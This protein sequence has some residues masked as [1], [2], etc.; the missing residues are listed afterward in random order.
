MSSA[1]F[2]RLLNEIA[3]NNITDNILFHIMGEPLLHPNIMDLLRYTVERTKRQHLVTNGSLFN[4]VN[5]KECYE[6]QLTHLSISYFTPNHALF[7]LRNPTNITFLDYQQTIQDVVQSKFEHNYGTH[8]RLFYPNINLRSFTW[9]GKSF[10]LLNK[11]VINTI[12]HTW[13]DFLTELGIQPDTIRQDA[14]RKWNMKKRHS[15]FMTDDFEIVFKPIH[16]WHNSN[17]NVIQAPIGKCSLVLN[18]EQLGILSNGDVVLCCGDYDGQTTFGNITTKSLTDILN[19]DD[20]HNIINRFSKGSIPFD[21][22]KQCLGSQSISSLMWKS[23][24]K[25]YARALLT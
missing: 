16:N 14:I 7:K 11:R 22:C 13:T 5:I 9:D 23:I 8:L 24:G 6:T 25:Y 15:V 18:H 1:T 2:T 4:D 10:E 21:M 20:Y 3:A 12:I 17:S 19:S